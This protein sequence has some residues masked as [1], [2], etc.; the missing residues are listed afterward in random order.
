M[1]GSIF[2]GSPI[3]CSCSYDVADP[4]SLAVL[5]VYC[6]YM[7]LYEEGSAVVHRNDIAVGG[8]GDQSTLGVFAPALQVTV[9]VLWPSNPH[10]TQVTMQHHGSVIMRAGDLQQ[11]KE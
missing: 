9:T 5:H 2:L 8:S 1:V 4:R 7:T 3:H 11:A 10:L 6:P